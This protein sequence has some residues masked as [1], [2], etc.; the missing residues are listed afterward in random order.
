MTLRRSHPSFSVIS[1]LILSTEA[2]RDS[3]PEYI[4]LICFSVR[5]FAK[6]NGISS[7]SLHPFIT[8]TSEDSGDDVRVLLAI[9]CP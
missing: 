3:F 9:C 2:S 8:S 7:S 6:L 4:N 5:I 1:S